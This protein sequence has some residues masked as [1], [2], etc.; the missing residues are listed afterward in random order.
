MFIVFIS[1]MMSSFNRTSIVE[2]YLILLGL[3]SPVVDH[4][5]QSFPDLSTHT[6]YFRLIT[7]GL[8]MI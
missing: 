7:P 1:N 8:V 2:V 6:F 4:Y 3:S 5:D